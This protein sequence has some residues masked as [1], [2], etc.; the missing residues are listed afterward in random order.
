MRIL[1]SRTDALGD[2]VI[3]LPVQTRILERCPHA[4]VHWLVRPY[5]APLLELLPGISGVHLREP[6]TDLQQLFLKLKPDAVLNLSHRDRAILP[7]AKMA[8]VPM[9]VA[10]ARGLGQILAATHL[11]WQSRRKTNHHEAE[12]ALDFLA[13]F[14]WQGG[15][16]T[17]PRL[18]LAETER[19]QGQQELGGIP[20]PRLGVI[21]R[22][23]GSGAF[24][25][26]GWWAAA[27][28]VLTKAGW[29]P[30]VLSPPEDSPLR[31]ADLRGLLARMAACDAIVGPSTGP[32]HVA[33]AL[34]V[35]VLCLMGLRSNHAPARWTPLGGQV[36][37]IQYPGA[38]ADLSGG[39]DK[40]DPEALLTSLSRFHLSSLKQDSTMETI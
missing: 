36:Q 30:V 9:R 29:N 28:M 16:P 26:P 35:P 15:L 33:A 38:E 19:Q 25:S 18:V 22:G 24:P 7:A 37:V 32:T 20:H 8:G 40:L 31:P 10:R 1:I 27:L 11:I 3:S 13:P 34:D 5:A 14:G 23:S 2:V 6:G 39:M 17:P 4:E 12:N 21:T